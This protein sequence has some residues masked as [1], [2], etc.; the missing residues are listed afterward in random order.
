MGHL[1]DY[2]ISG[3]FEGLVILIL[4]GYSTLIWLM[5]SLK[6]DPIQG[7]FFRD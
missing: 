4:K 6:M 1:E 3:G 7:W 5:I 2:V